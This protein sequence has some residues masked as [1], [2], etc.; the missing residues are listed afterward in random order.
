MFS[1]YCIVGFIKTGKSPHYAEIDLFAQT[2]FGSFLP[3]CATGSHFLKP[4][5]YAHTH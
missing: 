5:L 2:R 4:I 1:Q 3:Q